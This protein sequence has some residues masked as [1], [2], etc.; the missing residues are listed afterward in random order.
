MVFIKGHIPSKKTRLKISLSNKGKSP[1]NKIKR[2]PKRCKGCNK[3][4]TV[5]KNR[6]HNAL[7]CSKD[8]QYLVMT[9]RKPWNKD[10]KTNIVPKTAFKKGYVPW[11]KGLSKEDPRIL[12][13][14]ET[15]RK[16]DSYKQSE[17]SKKK[18]RKA[19][20]MQKFP[21]NDTKIEVILQ[22]ALQEE[23]IKYETQKYSLP[24]TPDI[25]IK[26]NVCIFADG[27]YWHNR[28]GEQKKDKRI[29]KQLKD[30]D[31]IV[32]RFWEHE[33]LTNINNCIKRIKHEK[34]KR[35]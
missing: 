31:Y 27:D 7:T 9:R 32:L 29:N 28:P 35:I 30:M 12:K 16:T 11:N 20:A 24:G 2:K 15:R 19:R 3:L 6:P 23:K 21:F 13:M 10:K 34:R 5:P 33:I 14:I 22:K 25:F 17:K 1:W 4:F 18:I 26:P 8:C